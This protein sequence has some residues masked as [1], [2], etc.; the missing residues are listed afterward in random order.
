ME[1]HRAKR[2]GLSCGG[3]CTSHHSNEIGKPVCQCEEAEGKEA[4]ISE[5]AEGWTSPISPPSDPECHL[6]TGCSQ[7][8]ASRSCAPLYLDVIR[9]HI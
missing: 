2:R 7:L 8:I 5:T 3:L 6:G 4:S 9:R 1:S